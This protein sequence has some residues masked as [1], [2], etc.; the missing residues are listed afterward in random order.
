MKSTNVNGTKPIACV[1]LLV[2][3]QMYKKLRTFRF[4]A[5]IMSPGCPPPA[6]HRPLLGVPAV[7]RRSMLPAL[8]P[9]KK[10]P[11]RIGSGRLGGEGNA[12]SLIS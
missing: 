2:C 12:H 11:P 7:A 1:L 5:P 3:L 8:P 4:C 10:K 6:Y 9:E